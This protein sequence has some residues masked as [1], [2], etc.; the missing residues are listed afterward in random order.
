[1]RSWDGIVECIFLGC[2][3]DSISHMA[4]WWGTVD[5]VDRGDCAQ[6]VERRGF[7]L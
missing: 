5:P 1:M 6:V 7:H 3:W 4:S 2:Q